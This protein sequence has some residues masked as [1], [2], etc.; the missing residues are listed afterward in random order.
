MCYNIIRMSQMRQFCEENVLKMKD[1]FL[2]N[3][4]SESEKNKIT[5]S[6]PEPIC[7]KK[8]E[9]IYSADKFSNSLGFICSGEAFAVTNNGQGI[10]MKSF[11]IGATFGAAAIFGG[12]DRYVSTIIAKTDTE[13]LFISEE[14][15]KEIFILYPKTAINYISFLSDKVRF[16]NKKL[17]VLSCSNTE[18]TVLNYLRS[19]MDNEGYAAIPKNMTLFSKMLGIGRASLY[20]S[21]DNLED[22]GSILREN[23]KIKVINNEKNY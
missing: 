21:L 9:I 18:D 13:V 22:S 19:V 14:A 6:F 12:E 5:A 16:L 15:L 3:N 7:F 11:E 1:L 20:R 23:N 4:L 8:G 2:L 10:Y 17:S